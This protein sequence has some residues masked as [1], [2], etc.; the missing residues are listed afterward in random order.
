MTFDRIDRAFAPKAPRVV[1]L[2]CVGC[3]TTDD[4]VAL[5][6]PVFWQVASLDPPL[7]L[8][9]A[10]G[11]GQCVPHRLLVGWPVTT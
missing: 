4:H 7:A 8:C 1:K 6:T 9:L 3:G 10:C 11:L 5:R 2:E